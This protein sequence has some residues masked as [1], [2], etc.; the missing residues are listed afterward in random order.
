MIFPE[1]LRKQN[2]QIWKILKNRFGERVFDRFPI[3][4]DFSRCKFTSSEINNPNSDF[5]D[6]VSPD[7][8]GGVN[9]DSGI[10]FD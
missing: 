5:G 1:E 7:S 9:P 4:V 6:M 2:I 10:T 8:Y 3:K